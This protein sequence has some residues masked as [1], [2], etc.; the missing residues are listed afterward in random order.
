MTVL[1]S[2]CCS[3]CFRYLHSAINFASLTDSGMMMISNS[4]VNFQV[5]FGLIFPPPL[6]AQFLECLDWLVSIM[7]NYRFQLNLSFAAFLIFS[8]V[9]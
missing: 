7:D 1:I 2:G 6:A 4:L 8:Y 3:V 5:C 9:G